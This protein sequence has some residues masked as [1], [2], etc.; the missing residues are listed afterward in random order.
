MSSRE[1]VLSKIKGSLRDVPAGEQPDDVPVPPVHPAPPAGGNA[2]ELFVERV[3]EYRGAVR[4]VDGAGI[5]AAVRN[6]CAETLTGR[7]LIAPGI[8]RTW[9]PTGVQTVPDTDFG[10]AE[11]DAFDGVLTGCCLAI[12]ETGTIVL[13]GGPVSGRRAITLVPDLHICIVG[14]DQIVASVPE[15]ILRLR[16]LSR[17]RS[18]LTFVSGP[19]ATSD[20]E[21]RRVEGVH[22]P[23]R[24]EVV[25]VD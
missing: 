22:G 14:S 15:A 9:L 24:L 12:A 20:I 25:L 17:E 18:P 10:A 1:R 21:F 23:R 3:E 16:D 7:L 5:S 2:V 19:S 13:D 4:S 8:D 6:L 11:L